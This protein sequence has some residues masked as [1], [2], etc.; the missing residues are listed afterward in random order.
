M[1]FCCASHQSAAL[2]FELFAATCTS[3]R[4][5]LRP[6]TRYFCKFICSAVMMLKKD[7]K[8]L[9]CS[10]CFLHHHHD[11]PSPS[12]P[13]SSYASPSPPTPSPPPTHHCYHR[14]SGN[15]FFRVYPGVSDLGR[16]CPPQSREI[17]GFWGG[18]KFF[19][20]AGT[21]RYLYFQPCES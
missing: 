1:G 6:H 11:H 13:S 5:Q 2:I 19:F 18:H 3:T 16:A 21:H 17:N 7:F 8:S 10:R 9:S 14:P 15:H 4:T 20:T 12:P